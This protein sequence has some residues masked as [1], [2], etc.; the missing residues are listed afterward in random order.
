MER[1]GI[2]PRKYTYIYLKELLLKVKLKYDEK[3]TPTILQKESGIHRSIW[4]R[5][6]GVLIQ[7]VNNPLVYDIDNQEDNVFLPN[8]GQAIHDNYH[9]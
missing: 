9:N 1:I 4:T 7:E 6:L 8:I 2:G 3:I 5:R